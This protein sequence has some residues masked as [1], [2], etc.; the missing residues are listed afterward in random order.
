[1][2]KLVLLPVVIIL[3]SC[4]NKKNESADGKISTDSLQTVSN[5]NSSEE[6]NDSP[7]TVDEIKAEYAVLNNQLIAKKLDSTSFDY[8]CEEVSGNVV[9]YT[10][11]GELKSIK[12]FH[13]DSHFSSVENYYLKNGKLYFIF[14][15]DTLWSFDGGTTEKPETKDEI[16]QQRIYIV[17]DKAIECLEKKFTIKSSAKNNPNPENIQNVPSENCSYSALQKTFEVLL[18]NKDQ[19]GKINCIL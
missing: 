11:N 7:Q 13:A 1:M 15:D 2:K 17:N 3:F 10:Q 5:K 6:D 19:K 18:K 9:Y 16:E 12:H 4:E 8:E 14:K